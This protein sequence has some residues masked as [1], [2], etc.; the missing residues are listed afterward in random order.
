MHRIVPQ[1]ETAWYGQTDAHSR[2]DMRT[3]EGRLGRVFVLRLDDDD[4]IPDCIERF[5]ADN[6]VGAAQV[7]LLGA[8]QTGDVVVGP[9]D[10]RATPVSPLVLPVDGVHE[11][12]GMGLLAPNEKGEPRLHLHGALGR[13]GGTVTGCLRLGATV[14]CMVEAIIIE[15]LDDKVRRIPDDESG[16]SMLSL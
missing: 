14:W 13:A 11:L 12:L 3:T 9:R 2:S 1:P 4:V 16:L 8:V 15:I 6:R 5:A 7:S 10:P